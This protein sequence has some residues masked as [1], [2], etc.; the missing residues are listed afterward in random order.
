MSRVN[1]K[2]R[3]DNCFA[4]LTPTNLAP[5]IPFFPYV[6]CHDCYPDFKDVFKP[7]GKT[8]DVPLC[9]TGYVA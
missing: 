1:L 9:P 4:E 5:P 8:P 2:T 7:L 3:C 6:L